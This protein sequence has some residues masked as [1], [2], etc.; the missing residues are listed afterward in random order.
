MD[1][2]MKSKDWALVY[3]LNNGRMEDSGSQ[4]LSRDAEALKK[5]WEA[6]GGKGERHKVE[7]AP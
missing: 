7:A 4:F 1:S 5:F 6:E 3:E 2:E